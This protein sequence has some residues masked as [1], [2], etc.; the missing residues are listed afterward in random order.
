[1]LKEEKCVEYYFDSHKYNK[2]QIIEFIEKEK[3][4]FE[5][6]RF[7]I[8]IKLNEYGIYIVKLNFLNNKLIMFKKKSINNKEKIR[9]KY[10]GYETYSGENKVY[11]KYKNTKTFQPI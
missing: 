4:G 6:K 7:E 11:G 8:N 5:N 9:K 2:M 10:K 3:V 1:M